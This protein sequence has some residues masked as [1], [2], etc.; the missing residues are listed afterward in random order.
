[1]ARRRDGAGMVAETLVHDR[2][3]LLHLGKKAP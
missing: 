1:M 3:F 2:E